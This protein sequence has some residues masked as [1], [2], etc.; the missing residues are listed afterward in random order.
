MQ[1][2][3]LFSFDFCLFLAILTHFVLFFDI[4]SIEFPKSLKTQINRLCV[5]IYKKSTP[6]SALL[7]CVNRLCA[8]RSCGS[9]RKVCAAVTATIVHMFGDI[10]HPPIV[11][12]TVVVVNLPSAMIL[13][14]AIIVRIA[15]VFEACSG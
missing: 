4:P 11:V 10:T 8:Y 5:H 1:G 12:C 7:I 3:C 9:R 15:V 2:F 14:M 6:K 13:R